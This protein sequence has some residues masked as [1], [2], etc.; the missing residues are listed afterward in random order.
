LRHFVEAGGTLLLETGFASYDEHMVYNPIVPAFGLADAF[1]Y[2]EQESLYI[3]ENDPNATAKPIAASDRVYVDG[4]LTFTEPIAATIKAHTF[5]TPITVSSAK[6]IASYESMAVAAVKKVGKGQVYYF[7]TNLGASIEDG[8]DE[9][10]ALIRTIVTQVVRPAI[11]SDK[12]RPRLIESSNGAL[13]IVCNDQI[14]DQSARLT[15]PSR[16]K[17]AMDIYEGRSQTIHDGVLEV[18]TPY[19][20]VTVL[21]LS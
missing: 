13:L 3:V 6:V 18:Q 19:Q 14:T 21:R 8:S 4:S 17:E 12:V 7:G 20:G 15:V 10:L 5:L 16:Y 1:G 11:T 2:R 9:G